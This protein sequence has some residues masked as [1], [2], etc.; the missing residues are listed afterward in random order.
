MINQYKRVFIDAETYCNLDIK[1][2]GMYKYVNDESFNVWCLAYAFDNEDIQLWTNNCGMPIRLK[3]AFKDDKVKIYAHNAEFEWQVLKKIGYSI[4]L[5]RWVDTQALAGAFGYPLGLDKFCKALGLSDGK[6]S[7][8]TRLINKLCKPQKKTIK[9][10]VGKWFPATAPE[11]FQDL[12]A[13]CKQD[14]RVMRKAVKKLPAEQ[15]ST[16]EQYVWGHTLIQNE[17]GVGIDGIS[18]WHIRRKLLEFKKYSELALSNT[19]GGQVKTGKQVA[20]MKE[21]LQDCGLAIPDLTKNTVDVYLKKN[22]PTICRK[23]LELRKQLSHSST[24]KYDKMLQMQIEGRVKG[25]LVYYGSH[26]GRFAGRGLQVHNLP[27]AQVDDPEKTISDFKELEYSELVKKYPDINTTASKLVRPMI[28]AKRGEHLLVAD[29]SSIENI[30][31]HWSA[32]DE[33]TTQDFHDGLCQYKVYSAARL[34]IKYDEVTKEQ[35]T[36]S[37]PDVLGLGYGGGYRALISVAAGY[38]VTLSQNE[39]QERVN[40]YR[41]KYKLI[42]IFWRNVFR[43]AKEA[44]ETEDPQILI[45]PTITLEFRCAGGYLFILLPSGRRLSYPQVKLDSVWRINVKGRQI[46]MSSD[47]SY[48]GVKSGTWLRIGTHP[49]MLVENIIQ[50]LARDLLVYGL[51]CAEQA[52]YKILMSVHDEAIAEGLHDEVTIEEFCDYL[53][54]KPKWATTLPVKA[55]GYL[56]KRYKKG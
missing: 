31:L 44:I 9:N 49:G 2:V 37:K 7:K 23:V 3:E 34:G 17:R 46:P 27:R 43:K 39:A 6:D 50:A 32:G 19:T 1:Q 41:N 52:G 24:A 11:D 38:G 51:L 47:I 42:P 26:T 18:A 13:Y 45:T 48:M 35:R 53:C 16:L 29:Y 36:Q 30:V 40:F 22:I 20:K 55:E 12:Y 33:K 14:V 56:S 8:G 5:R 4:P 54:T 25:N 21:F 10:P 15:L 28:M